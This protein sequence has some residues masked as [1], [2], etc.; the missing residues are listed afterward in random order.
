LRIEIIGKRDSLGKGMASDVLNIL[1]IKEPFI[2][3][4][5]LLIKNTSKENDLYERTR[6]Y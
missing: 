1:L 5:P 2:L 3:F 4:P 6:I